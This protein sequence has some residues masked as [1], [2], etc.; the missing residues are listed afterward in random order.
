MSKLL[1]GIG[2]LALLG[3]TG[4]GF[5]AW[6]LT[7]EQVQITIEEGAGARLAAVDPTAELADRFT[8]L[9]GDLRGLAQSLGRN[10][11]VLDEAAAEREEGAARAREADRGERSREIARLEQAFAAQLT[12]ALDA[13]RQRHVGAFADLRAEIAALRS[14]L[15]ERAP[16]EGE[17]GLAAVPL[18]GDSSSAPPEEQP[19]AA[20]GVPAAPPTVPAAPPGD[21]ASA[22]ELAA[23]AGADAE[24]VAAPPEKPKKKRSFVAFDLPS[25]SFTFEG[26]RSWEVVSSLSRVGFDAK[27]TLHDFTGVTQK[28]KGTWTADLAQPHVDPQGA[29]TVDAAS[30]DT[31]LP[32]RDTAMYEKLETSKH[33][34]ITFAV[35]AFRATSVDAKAMKVTGVVRGRLG[36]HGVEREI[37]MPVKLAIDDARR[38]SVEGELVAKMSEWGLEP[39]SQL[40]MISVQDQVKIWIALRARSTGAAAR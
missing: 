13:E 36:I 8:A 7:K 33:A 18:E 19:S 32:D 10:F 17:G 3:W 31:G 6:M 28:L 21:P 38:L 25:D 12:Q 35:V 16:T 20:E 15:A 29:I 1:Q 24:P 4:A 5:G 9:Q 37:E 30:L 26:R 11:E 23:N 39:P 2:L 14:T 27:S 40:G 34:S 22:G